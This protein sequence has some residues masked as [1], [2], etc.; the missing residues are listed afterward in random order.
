M[1]FDG[2]YN[3]S[4]SAKK[5][6]LHQLKT[7]FERR[8]VKKEV[9]NSVHGVHSCREFLNFV[10]YGYTVIAAMRELNI[11]DKDEKPVGTEK[12]VDDESTCRAAEHLFEQWEEREEDNDH[13]NIVSGNKF[14]CTYPGC[15]KQFSSNLAVR[16]SIERTILSKIPAKNLR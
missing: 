6:T 13:H 5:G 7:R 14:N 1:M 12:E 15:K 16:K 4:F 3:G 8:K 9:K 11:T 10:T 2:L